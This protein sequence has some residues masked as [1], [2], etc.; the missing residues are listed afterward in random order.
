VSPGK[1]D[2]ELERV[3]VQ[4]ISKA[5]TKARY[6]PAENMDVDAIA[7]EIVRPYLQPPQRSEA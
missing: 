6:F 1:I 4:R 2:P 5:L 3:L 7:H